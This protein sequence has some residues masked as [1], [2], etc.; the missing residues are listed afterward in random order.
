MW[1]PF[2]LAVNLAYKESGEPV[3][4]ESFLI[5]PFFVVS[6][7]YTSWKFVQVRMCSFDTLSVEIN[8]IC[9]LI[10]N[11]CAMM[12]P[13]LAIFSFSL[14]KKGLKLSKCIEN[15]GDE[16]YPSPLRLDFL[17]TQCRTILKKCVDTCMAAC[18]AL[19]LVSILK[20]LSLMLFPSHTY[21][22]S[23]SM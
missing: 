8:N 9:F 19:C 17:Q 16:V 15:R 12:L 14:W 22:A 20:W 10:N 2:I 23:S 18:H 11:R 6:F 7:V 1:L 3:I 13:M 21:S 4:D 5:I